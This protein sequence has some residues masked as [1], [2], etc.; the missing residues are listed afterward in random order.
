V[1][2]SQLAGTG[3]DL[4][5]ADMALA[6]LINQQD[7]VS[8]TQVIAAVCRHYQVSLEALCSSN[9]SRTV[10]FPRQMAMYLARTETDASFPQIGAELGNRDHTTIIHGH[11]KISEMMDTTPSVR[12]DLLAIKSLLYNQR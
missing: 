1:A 2:Y 5:L 11:D 4:R 10:A 3:I 7:K 8:L 12:Q 6:D 9:R